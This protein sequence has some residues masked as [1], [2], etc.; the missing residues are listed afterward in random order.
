MKVPPDAVV[1]PEQEEQIQA[2][3]ELAED[4]SWAIVPFGGGTSAKLEQIWSNLSELSGFPEPYLSGRKTTYRRWSSVYSQQ[5]I[6]EDIRD[7]TGIKSIGEMETLCHLLSSKIGNP[8]SVP[9]LS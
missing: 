8:I 6:R 2:V 1:F 4:R 5:L 9:A 7:I 3:L